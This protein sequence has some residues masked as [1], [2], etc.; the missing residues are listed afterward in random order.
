M[1]APSRCEKS[2]QTLSEGSRRQEA[3]SSAKDGKSKVDSGGP[4]GQQLLLRGAAKEALDRAPDWQD[5]GCPGLLWV[6]QVRGR[7]AGIS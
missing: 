3:K 4:W 7:G 2:D 5:S 1:R 6:R